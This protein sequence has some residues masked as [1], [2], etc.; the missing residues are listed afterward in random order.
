MMIV[1]LG[2]GFI[3]PPVGVNLFVACSMGNVAFEAVA[4]KAIPMI[5]V[6]LIGLLLVTFIPAL[7]LIIPQVLTGYL[8]GFVKY[9]KGV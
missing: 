8:S 2:I 9:V 4:I 1:N 6:M 3:T 5:L 7:S